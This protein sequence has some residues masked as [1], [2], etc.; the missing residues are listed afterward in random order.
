M[1]KA[2]RQRRLK[3]EKERQRRRMVH[4]R[5]GGHG[6]PQPGPSR[7]GMPP[8]PGT[9][10]PRSG[11]LS[12]R[13]LAALGIGEA[14]RALAAGSTETFRT[15]VEALASQARPGMD[16]TLSRELVGSRA[17]TPVGPPLTWRPCTLTAR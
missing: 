12:L 8:P 9:P 17:G 6:P 1:G 5:S 4:A 10:P 11:D 13:E 15:L 7:R 16:A 14:L 2:A 3:K